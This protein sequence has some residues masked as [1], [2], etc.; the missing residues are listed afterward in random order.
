MTLGKVHHQQ[1]DTSFM[2]TGWTKNQLCFDNRT[3][4]EVAGQLE[5]WFNVHVTITDDNLKLRRFTAVFEDEGLAKVMEALRISG[6][7]HYAIR[8]KEVIISP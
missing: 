5:R 3:L 1:N 4:E 7:F 2:E 6:D 8:K